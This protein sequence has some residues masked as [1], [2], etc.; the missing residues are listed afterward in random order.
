MSN[1]PINNHGNLL[2]KSKWNHV[3][4][5]H[6]VTAGSATCIQKERFALF[7]SAENPIEIAM[8]ENETSA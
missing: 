7:M 1:K 3:S 8:T 6:A 2:G 5:M 4:Q